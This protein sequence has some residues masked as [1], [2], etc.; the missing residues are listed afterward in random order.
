M[1]CVKVDKGGFCVSDKGER[2]RLVLPYVKND[3]VRQGQG[4]L[5]PSTP[6]TLQHSPGQSLVLY[7]LLCPLVT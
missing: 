6:P 3:A 7:L 4:L 1:K 5:I 2:V